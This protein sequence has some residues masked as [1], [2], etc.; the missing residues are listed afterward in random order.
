MSD[1]DSDDDMP[2]P[3][4]NK[5]IVEVAPVPAVSEAVATPAPAPAIAAVVEPAQ[6]AA[7]APAPA[8]SAPKPKAW[9]Q[10]NPIVRANSSNT[11]TPAVTP[12]STTSAPA[13]RQQQQQS[14]P[15]AAPTTAAAAALAPAAEPRGGDAAHGRCSRRGARPR[16]GKTVGARRST[17]RLGGAEGVRWCA[18]PRRRFASYC[19]FV[20]I[21]SLCKFSVL[22]FRPLSSAYACC[23]LSFTSS[24]PLLL[25][26]PFLLLSCGYSLV[27]FLRVCV[28]VFVCVCVVPPVFC[29]AG[30]NALDLLFC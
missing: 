15:K 14:Q 29:C 18:C 25:P 26:C 23:C 2:L 30:N 11:H 9:G 10:S 4:V 16:V 8:A 5:K 19:F 13:Q 27:P 22:F 12:A 24:S 21:S 28:C 6:P 17:P 1:G 7:P 3:L 20:W